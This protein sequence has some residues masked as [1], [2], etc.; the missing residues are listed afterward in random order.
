[1]D[2][3]PAIKYPHFV[4]NAHRARIQI[5]AESNARGNFVFDSGGWRDN[6]S[7]EA[8]GVEFE[9]YEDAMAAVRKFGGSYHKRQVL[10]SESEHNNQNLRSSNE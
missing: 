10:L 8:R 7:F 1:M 5:W 3:T 2:S 4:L 6:V 9:L